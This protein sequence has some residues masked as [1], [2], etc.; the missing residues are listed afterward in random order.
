MLSPLRTPVRVANAPSMMNSPCAR[1]ITPRIPKMTARPK[2]TK[3]RIEIVVARS[4]PRLKS[5]S[6]ANGLSLLAR[7]GGGSGDGGGWA[8]LLSTPTRRPMRW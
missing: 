2:D 4:K 3:A 8:S 6:A 5:R 1:L 7:T